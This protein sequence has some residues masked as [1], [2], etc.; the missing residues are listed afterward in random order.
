[1]PIIFRRY[2]H[3]II[4]SYSVSF[5]AQLWMIAISFTFS[6]FVGS[7]ERLRSTYITFNWIA[8]NVTGPFSWFYLH[9]ARWN[10]T[11]Q[12]IQLES[13]MNSMVK[14]LFSN[15][16]IISIRPHI[17]HQQ[18]FG[19]GFHSSCLIGCFSWH[20]YYIYTPLHII[21]FLFNWFKSFHS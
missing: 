3:A 21:C 2:F 20:H 5:S 12:C 17:C 18:S 16:V 11:Q 8:Y 6:V 19:F 10:L 15:D 7:A 13:N 14:Q 4:K 1:M 9:H